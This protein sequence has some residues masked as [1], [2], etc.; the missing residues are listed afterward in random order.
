M[1][2]FYDELA[3]EDSISREVKESAKSHTTKEETIEVDVP[4]TMYAVAYSSFGAPI[5][6]FASDQSNGPRTFHSIASIPKHEK[7]LKK[8]GLKLDEISA[9]ESISF[10]DTRTKDAE[11]K[12]TDNTSNDGSGDEQSTTSSK[13]ATVQEEIALLN[14]KKGK[15][16]KYQTLTDER[17]HYVIFFVEF[18]S[19][20][21]FLKQQIQKRKGETKIIK[22][23]P[24]SNKMTLSILDL[25]Y[26]E[27]NAKELCRFN[28]IV[29]NRK[30]NFGRQIVGGIHYKP[31]LGWKFRSSNEFQP[32]PP[33]KL[34]V[35]L[36]S[37]EDI[38]F[39][40]DVYISLWFNDDKC[41][42]KVIKSKNPKFN[43]IFE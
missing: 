8:K 26:G 41:K 20:E 28:T 2:G 29:N 33:K 3:R 13:K 4:Y 40:S 24:F 39:L 30:N 36:E 42:T 21:F 35:K 23:V 25:T 43:E 34:I 27:D 9:F 37:V 15:Q 6:Y 16:D 18:T 32:L 38:P 11:E 1:T 19:P 5:C 17:F 22:R 31:K 12:P 14:L 10:L 7:T